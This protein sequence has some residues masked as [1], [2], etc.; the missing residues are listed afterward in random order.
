MTNNTATM[1]ARVHLII[2]SHLP[3]WLD[4]HVAL[5]SGRRDLV[6]GLSVLQEDQP[7]G[8]KAVHDLRVC[9]VGGLVLG[10]ERARIGMTDTCCVYGSSTY[11]NS[12]FCLFLVYTYKYR[13][14]HKSLLW[15]SFTT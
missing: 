2:L 1:T 13:C 14:V 15:F 10:G 3:C 6:D 11:S 12:L 9:A 4:E 8:R 5:I 7:V